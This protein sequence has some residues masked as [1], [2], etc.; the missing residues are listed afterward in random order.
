MEIQTDTIT[1]QDQPVTVKAYWLDQISDFEQPIDY[2]V[3][4][5]CPG[6]AFKFQSDREAEP[7]ALQY[8]AMGMHAVILNYQLIEQ[9]PVYPMALAQ[10]AATIAW[11]DQQRALRHI[12]RARILLTGFSA[13][14]HLVA[15]Y[16]AL[17][18]Q[19]KWRKTYNLSQYGGSH[20]AVVLNYPVIDF[21]L[22]F[23][24]D[25][26]SKQ[27]IS[28]DERLWAAQTFV[29]ATAKPT[30]IWQTNQDTTV[31][32][33]NAQAY[34]TALQAAQVPVE[35]HLFTF[36]KHG[37]SLATHTTAKPGRPEYLNAAT[38]MWLPL[39]KNWLQMM[40]LLAQ[41]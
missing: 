7:I 3:M 5:I 12:D 33:K 26:A 30:F 28:P 18:T 8:N 38:A 17:A 40:Q 27:L 9:P 34:V 29:T 39:L 37:L 35:Y 31:P 16:N 15:L 41:D 4:I 6:G 2:P 14:G 21:S 11:V 32:A 24:K 20:A 13:G 25:A 23:P 19:P 10:L 22:G 36:G 1:V